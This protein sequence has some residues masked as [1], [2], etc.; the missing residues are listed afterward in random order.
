LT[1]NRRIFWT[2]GILL[3]LSIPSAFASIQLPNT[4]GVPTDF[5]T[6]ATCTVATNY[7]GAFAG[8][9][10]VNPLTDFKTLSLIPTIPGTLAGTVNVAFGT[11]TTTGHLDFLYQYNPSLSDFQQLTAVNFLA[12]L[13]TVDLGYLTDLT[14]ITG[15]GFAAPTTGSV[16][17]PTGLAPCIPVTDD[18]QPAA[19]NKVDFS[20]TAVNAIEVNQKSP[21]LVIR[22]LVDTHGLGTVFVQDGGNG[23]QVAYDPTPEPASAGVLLG[24]LLG[25]GLFIARK[26]QVKQG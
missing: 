19:G 18:W 23:F 13:G 9:T 1:L 11:D 26:F 14:K 25:V 5:T 8:V 16:C 12:S 22:T 21:I 3:F 10:I 15:G 17:G 4:S 6:C 2:A 20:F 24:G 7:G